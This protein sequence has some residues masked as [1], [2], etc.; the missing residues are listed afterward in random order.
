MLEKGQILEKGEQRDELAKELPADIAELV[1]KPQYAHYLQIR[2]T[3]PIEDTDGEFI[4]IAVQV[5]TTGGSVS[6]R[7]ILPLR[8]PE[9]R[10]NRGSLRVLTIGIAPYQNLPKLQF[11]DLDAQ[12]LG[13][14]FKAQ[15]R[16]DGLYIGADVTFVTNADATLARIREALDQFTR[17]VRPG[18]TLILSVSG[19]GLKRGDATYFAPVRCDPEN[20]EGTGLP[21]NEVLAKLEEARKTARAVWVL[22]DC[23]RAAPGLRRDVTAATSRDLKRGVEEGG[24][25]IICTASSG[26]TPSYESEDLKHGIFTAAWLEA[27]NG[28]APSLVYQDVARGKVLTLS[29]LQFAVDSAVIRLARAAG[30]RQRVEFPRLEGSFSPSLP[31]FVP[32]AR[33]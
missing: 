2:L 1:K 23:C 19:H 24:N 7:R 31:V 28:E 27:L 6:D 14:A 26:D 15:D 5:E 9:A 18:D 11:A 3:V 21:W 30:V 32:V 16:V 4:R 12:D 29:G 20:V 8:R 13:L 17:N 25:L 10:M 22:A 33:E